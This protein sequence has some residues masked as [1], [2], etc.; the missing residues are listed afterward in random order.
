M[1]QV[2]LQADHYVTNHTLVHFCQGL[3]PTWGERI[4]VKSSVFFHGGNTGSNPVGDA[5]FQGSSYFGHDV[6]TTDQK[7]PQCPAA[8]SFDLEKDSRIPE[9]YLPALGLRE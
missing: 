2:R 5:N 7:S 6:V 1:V 3:Y 4:L 9:R 8:A